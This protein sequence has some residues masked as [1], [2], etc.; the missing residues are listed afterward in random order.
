MYVHS[1]SKIISNDGKQPK[2]TFTD[3]IFSLSKKEDKLLVIVDPK[4]G[5]VILPEI[6]QQDSELKCLHTSFN[7]FFIPKLSD[8]MLEKSKHGP[9]QTD[10]YYTS[11]VEKNIDLS[12]MNRKFKLPNG[13]FFYY[14]LFDDTNQ[15]YEKEI[16]RL[17]EYIN[18]K[19]IIFDPI[20]QKSLC[21]YFKTKRKSKKLET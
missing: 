15:R 2:K 14:F 10:V 6:I 11:K 13:K 4:K 19:V 5:T 9:K 20:L 17:K 21:Q 18:T 1:R 12:K 7:L 16:N 3:A 8:M